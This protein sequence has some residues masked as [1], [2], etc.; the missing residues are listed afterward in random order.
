MVVT[1]PLPFIAA[2]LNRFGLGE[3]PHEHKAGEAVKAN[4]LQPSTLQ[5]QELETLCA[6]LLKK[7]SLVTSGKLQ[8]IGLEKVK[9]R[10]GRKWPAMQQEVY[11]ISEDVI[12]MHLSKGDIHLRQKD[13]IYLI[14]FAN[15]SREQGEFTAGAIS[16]EI[17]DR[18]FA[19]GKEDLRGIA[20]KKHIVQTQS[21]LLSGKPLCEILDKFSTV[22][23]EDPPPRSEEDKLIQPSGAPI[24]TFVPL[25]EVRLNAITTYLCRQ[26]GMEQG[27]H[28]DLLLLSRAIAELQRF[29]NENRPALIMCP[30]RHATLC[31]PAYLPKYELLCKSIPVAQ[32]N[33]L[34]FKLEGQPQSAL[35]VG[36]AHYCFVL[37]KY[38][39]AVFVE[40]MA[41]E[42]PDLSGLR[43]A[44]FDG[45]GLS[46]GAE[47]QPEQ[48][49]IKRLRMF[50]L[51]A[52]AARPSRKFLLDVPTISIAASAVCMGFDYISGPV[53][54][55][56][57]AQPAG[58]L[59]YRHS[60]LVKGARQA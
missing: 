22:P 56:H 40:T 41:D 23:M 35:K 51:Q 34:I 30:V 3:A 14:I 47:Q 24:F 25:W 21:G 27:P 11:A 9:R 33:Y 5:Q 6:E 28:A 10:L 52:D 2:F 20:I 7:R 32:R 13:D 53:V 18:L 26:E 54:C 15:A 36:G 50:S 19:T 46:I 45:A 43:H 12:S 42:I 4:A 48:A 44:G 1:S 58:I 16:D 29:Q 59:R 60:D 37:K 17:R 55:G 49:V 57:V 8:L 39:R 38:C 31:D